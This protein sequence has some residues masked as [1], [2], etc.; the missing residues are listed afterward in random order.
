MT[1]SETIVTNEPTLPPT[2][3]DAWAVVYLDV[4]ETLQ[5]PPA[6]SREHEPP[7]AGPAEGIHPVRRPEAKPDLLA[8]DEVA[9]REM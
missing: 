3:A 5:D 8:E 7:Q 1:T 4:A 2:T 6:P 9:D